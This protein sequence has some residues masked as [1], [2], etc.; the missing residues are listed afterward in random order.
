MS[1]AVQSASQSQAPVL[2]A[3]QVKS[4]RLTLMA[5]SLALAALW[6]P[7]EEP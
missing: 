7:E 2:A 6:P 1:A 5:S 4:V 3:L